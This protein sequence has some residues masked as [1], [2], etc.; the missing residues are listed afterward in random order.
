MLRSPRGFAEHSV[1]PDRPLTS[2]SG[3]SVATLAKTSGKWIRA[4][5]LSAI[6]LCACVT[7]DEW[8]DHLQ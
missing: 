2:G 7:D 5:K 3:V 1:T 8:T 6:R 4:R